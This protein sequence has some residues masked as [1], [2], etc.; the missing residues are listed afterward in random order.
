MTLEWAELILAGMGTLLVM[1][2][3]LHS[4]LRSRE[5]KMQMVIDGI[6]L[7]I[8]ALKKEKVDEEDMKEYVQLWTKP[9]TMALGTLSE[10]TKRTRELMEK[11]YHEGSKRT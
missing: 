5:N 10:E 11:I 4:W 9:I 3:G 2:G 8:E 7:Q 1:V 6:K